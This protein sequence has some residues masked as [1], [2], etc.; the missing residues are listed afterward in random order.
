MD[1]RLENWG[2][3]GYAN[4]QGYMKVSSGEKAAAAQ[5]TAT[6]QYLTNMFQTQFGEQQNLL[7]AHLIP[8]LLQMATHPEGFGAGALA[9]MRSQ[10]IG[11]IG[12]QL[13]SQQESL[14]NNFATENM[15]G[16]GSGPLMG[17]RANM[18]STAAG[19]E[20]TALQ[21]I[22]IANA[23]AQMQEQQFALGGLGQATQM[24]GQAP[25][26]AGLAVK[27]IGQGFTQQYNMAQQGGFWSNLLRA[28]ATAAGG[29]LGAFADPTNPLAGAQ[30]GMAIGGATGGAMTGT[31]GAPMS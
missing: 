5:Q 24:L 9:S 31:G 10:A 21:N 28:G 27:S 8:Q 18:A 1:P 30:A 2:G 11:T 23:Q 13:Q 19:E 20:A 6:S 4:Y 16:L 14:A 7:M 26:A 3:P 25:E 17:L 29:A 22:S 15:A 12:A